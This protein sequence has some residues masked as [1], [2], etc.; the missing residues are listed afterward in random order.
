MMGKF[1]KINMKTRKKIT[2]RILWFYIHHGNFGIYPSWKHPKNIFPKL[3]E[4]Y[5]LTKLFDKK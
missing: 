1:K 3:I 4:L 2:A 5:G